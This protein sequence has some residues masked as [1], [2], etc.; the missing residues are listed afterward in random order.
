MLYGLPPM[1]SRPL[2]EQALREVITERGYRPGTVL[3]NQCALII[4][5][6]RSTPQPEQEYRIGRYRVDF[7]WPQAEIA[8]EADGW[9]HRS[10]E[11]AAKDRGRDSWLRS[12]GWIVFRVDDQYGPEGLA[13]QLLRVC[14]FVVSE[15]R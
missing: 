6:F 9:W 1:T 15:S 14:R 11:G 4:S 10:P 8:L 7:A 12:Q 3:E 13:G 5:R 2:Y